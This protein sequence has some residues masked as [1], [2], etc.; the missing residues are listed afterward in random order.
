VAG[1]DTL[2]DYRNYGLRVRETLRPW[3]EGEI[4]V[5]VDFDFLGGEVDFRDPDPASEATF[6]RE[7]WRI[8][9][10]HVAVSHRLGSYDGWY[11]IPSAGLR[12]SSHSEFGRE[13]APQVGLVA[14]FGGT[15]FHARYARGVNFPGL[16]VKVQNDVFLPGENLW[17]DLDAE[18][19][20]HYEIGVSHVADDDLRMDLT[21]FMDKGRD[22]IVVSPPPPFPPVLDNL[23]GYETRGAEATVTF[24]P[25]DGVSVFVGATYLDPEPRDLPYAPRWTA[26]AGVNV[27]CAPGLM[28]NVDAVL[29]DE[30]TVGSRARVKDTENANE[31]DGYFLLNAKISYDF[32]LGANG[33]RGRVDLAIENLTDTDYEHKVGYPMP[34]IGFLL[35]FSV[36][37]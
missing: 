4:L 18:T 1:R 17:D 34:G 25:A 5:G 35:G 31:V 33:P 16:Y 21:L 13:V 2:T 36:R 24:R 37:F 20:D 14:G 9:S 29:V 19:I 7:T 3:A 15:E 30:Q 23:G 28:L 10:P 8:V 22:R 32:D 6:D 12:Y 11:A 27:R 26:A